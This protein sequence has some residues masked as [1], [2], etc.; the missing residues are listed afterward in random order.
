MST[1]TL[2]VMFLACL[3]WSINDGKTT[4]VESWDFQQVVTIVADDHSIVLLDHEI[5]F[6]R[7]PF[8]F[9]LEAYDGAVITT[10]SPITFT[11]AVTSGQR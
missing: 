1:F 7:V 10:S 4:T 5:N 8:C 2:P 11:S 9:S 3:P 6:S